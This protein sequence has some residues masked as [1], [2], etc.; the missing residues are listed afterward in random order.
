M[1][2]IKII[3][4]LILLFSMQSIV[5]QYGQGGYGQGG[6]GQRGMGG[7]MGQD[8]MGG[9]MGGNP[10]MQNQQRSQPKEPAIEET[11]KKVMDRFNEQ[12][13]LDEL[14]VIA[15]SNIITECI[16][17]QNAILKK[18]EGGNEE[19]VN[20]L[21]AISEKMDLDILILLNKDQKA[22]YKL[23]SEDTKKQKEAY[24]RRNR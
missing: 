2:S 21:K 13:K 22:K 17:K 20:E 24:S 15:V 7:G 19:K 16:K 18:E 14:Q 1:K 5:A 3:C 10:N 6:M 11:V 23:L 8:G 12:L 4:S 9:G